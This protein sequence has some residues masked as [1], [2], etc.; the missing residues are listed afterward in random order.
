MRPRHPVERASRGLWDIS[1]ESPQSGDERGGRELPAN[2]HGRGEDMQKQSYGVEA[3][4]QHA[5]SKPDRAM[6]QRLGAMCRDLQR[7]C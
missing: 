2:P 4:G 1:P 5:L 3:D 6:D 7:D